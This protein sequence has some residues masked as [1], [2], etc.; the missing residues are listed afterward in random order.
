MARR[1]LHCFIVLSLLPVLSPASTLA[2]EKPSDEYIKMIV[3]LLG[4]SDREFRAAG[5]EKVRTSAKGAPATQIFA[6][7]LANLDAAGQTALLNA[8]A[9]RGD[10]TARTAILD[11]FVSSKDE[12]VR[13]SAIQAIGGLGSAADLP[14]LITA[15][16]ATSGVEQVATRRSLVQIRG[17]SINKALASE[18]KS[19]APGVKAAL[20]EVLA[21]RRA[22]DEL[23]ALVAATLDDSPQVRGAA[24]SALGQIGRPEQ[25]APMFA[26]APANV[27]LPD[28]FRAVLAAG[29]PDS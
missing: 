11:L 2:D 12:Q 7:Q 29:S 5:L 10:V 18:S 13:A 25:I 19:A 15:L 17:E 22:S 28:A 20:I 1:I 27:I 21:M 14:M 23:P 8:L 4:D 6:A 26:E 9:D 24:M 3:K 16:S